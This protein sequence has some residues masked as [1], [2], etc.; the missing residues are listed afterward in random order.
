MGDHGCGAS[1]L[2]R[3]LDAVA[4]ALSGILHGLVI[5]GGVALASLAVAVYV[6]ATQAHWSGYRPNRRRRGPVDIPLAVASAGLA[7]GLI[8]TGLAWGRWFAG[9]GWLDREWLRDLVFGGIGVGMILAMVSAVALPLALGFAAHNRTLRWWLGAV[10]ATIALAGLALYP[11]AV[12][13]IALGA[14]VAARDAFLHALARD[15]ARG[16]TGS[17]AYVPWNVA[18]YGS[19][20]A[21]AAAG[22]V[23]Q[24]AYPRPPP[25]DPTAAK[26]ATEERHDEP[27]A[28]GPA[29]AAVPT[30]G[31]ASA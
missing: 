21:V 1:T 30:P 29:A 26:P 31:A 23:A 5:A 18:L 20:S 9:L 14:D 6:R 24:Y 19:F 13:L 3:W 25:P 7:F 12:A 11:L 4:V 22:L 28:E 16:D 2:C 8:P 17:W 27:P 10:A 15:A